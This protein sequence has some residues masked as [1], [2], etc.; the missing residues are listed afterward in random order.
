MMR[1]WRIGI[2]L[3]LVVL[4]TA[5][6][7]SSALSQSGGIVVDG[8]DNTLEWAVAPSQTLMDLASGVETRYIVN[9][10]NTLRYIDL[11][12]MPSALQTLVA[13]VGDRFIILWANTK[14]DF[15]LQAIPDALGMLLTGVQDRPIILWANT[16]RAITPT[17]PTEL[18][19]DTEP[20]AIT[21]ISATETTTGT[22][23]IDW[24]T[25]EFADS[26]VEYGTQ[27]GYYTETVH[28]SLYTKEHRV[29]LSELVE[30]T[31][32]YFIVHSTDR[33]GN[34]AE[35]AEYRF[36]TTIPTYL[37]VILQRRR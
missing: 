12:P 29:L 7:A 19:S 31:V 25:D 16:N 28:D 32:Y 26:V 20:P 13:Q 37:P 3:F 9:Y 2:P 17:Y 36:T 30:S 34:A 11:S 18:I 1:T 33:S 21:G 22:T 8:A 10:A 35:S 24:F 15:T 6:I 5:F 23:N 14:H 27:P 4:A